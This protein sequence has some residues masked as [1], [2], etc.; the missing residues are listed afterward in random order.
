[1]KIALYGIGGTYNL[2]CE[3]II[4]GTEKI[5]H[6]KYPEAILDYY[7]YQ[8][9]ED[10]KRLGRINVNIIPLRSTTKSIFVKVVAKLD[11][12]F[13]KLIKRQCFLYERFMFPWIKNYD[14]ILSVGGDIYTLP[15]DS[16]CKANQKYT[17]SLIKFGEYCYY[18]KAKLIVWGASIGPFEKYPAIKKIFMDHLEKCIVYFTL[19]EENSYKYLKKNGFK[20]I[21]LI[22]DPAFTVCGESFERNKD[23]NFII[24]IN[25]SPLSGAYLSNQ[26]NFEE[27]I[28]QQTQ[29]IRAVTEYFGCRVYL[30]PHVF[31]KTV[32]DDDFSYLHSIYEELRKEKLDIELKEPKSFYEAK[33]Y[34]SE[35]SVVISA[36]MHCAINAITEGIPAIFLSYSEKTLGMS[37]MIYG[38]EKFALQL[39]E[40]NDSNKIICCIENIFDN[41]I[42][43]QKLIQTA[44]F[45]SRKLAYMAAN[46][47]DE[48]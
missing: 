27:M 6:A 45:K 43:I 7:S 15:P 28:K 4:R 40:F 14:Y 21:L 3:A 2:G 36:R 44:V 17:N 22:G 19:R 8:P 30:I 18:K 32:S 31:S 47:F 13:T 37:K 23:N 29:T 1:M 42:N 10:E 41:Y 25:L 35:C 48:V 33:E 26:G 11:G 39:N 38:T 9:T 16:E 12:L 20:N 34:L 24:G 46:I 5:I